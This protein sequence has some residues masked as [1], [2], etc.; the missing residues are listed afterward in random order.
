MSQTAPNKLLSNLRDIKM[1]LKWNSRKLENWPVMF[2]IPIGEL[3]H[4]IIPVLVN[5][6]YNVNKSIFSLP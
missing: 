2:T 4:L 6:N 3:W 5:L 1:L